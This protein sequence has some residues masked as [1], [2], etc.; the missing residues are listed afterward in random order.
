MFIEVV[1]IHFDFVRITWLVLSCSP[2][3]AERSV[4]NAQK[5]STEA[6]YVPLLIYQVWKNYSSSLRV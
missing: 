1:F 4:C 2:S 5:K 6:L 3:M